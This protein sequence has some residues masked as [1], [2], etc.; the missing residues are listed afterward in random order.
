MKMGKALSFHKQFLISVTNNDISRFHSLV[1]LA[2]GNK[3]SVEYIL[4]KCTPAINGFYR[5]RCNA[6][7]KDLAFLVLKFSRPSL[8][9][10]LHQ[11]K[12]FP[13]TSVAN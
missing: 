2:L 12:C 11:A 6:D 8:L 4:D 7:K 13:S 10:I 1:K 5:A 9:D 3:R